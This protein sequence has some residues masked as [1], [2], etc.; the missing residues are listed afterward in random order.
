V[1]YPYYAKKLVASILETPKATG[2]LI[3]ATGVGMSIAAN[4]RVGIRAALC[5]D[6]FTATRARSH[7]DAN[8]LVIG[9]KIVNPKL[10]CAM[11]DKFLTTNF[12]GG[13]HISRLSQID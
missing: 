3:C 7:N 4:R 10:A 5:F 1:D 11:L 6:E 8:V 13:R 9:E 2:I 12:E